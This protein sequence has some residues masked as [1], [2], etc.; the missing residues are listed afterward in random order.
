MRLRK[1]FFSLMGVLFV[2]VLLFLWLACDPLFRGALERYGP[3]ALGQPLSFDEAML[4]PLAGRA[5]ILGLKIG[6][7]ERPMIESGRLVAEVSPFRLLGGEFGIEL[8]AL[9][10]AT[11]RFR[12]D[13]QGRL[14]FDPGPPP[15][16]VSPE[17][18]SREQP[19]PTNPEDR[20][21]VEIVQEY[22]ERV[23][24]YKKYY[25]KTGLFG[26]GE[27][28][29]SA[30]EVPPPSRYRG[31]QGRASCLESD[32]GP[33]EGK[34]GRRFGIGHAGV[35]DL[36][37][38]TRDERTGKPILPV[39]DKLS[40]SMDRLGGVP[41]GEETPGRIAADG[42]LAGGGSF[43][44]ILELAR[45]AGP[46][47]LVLHVQGLSPSAFADLVRNSLPWRIEGRAIDLDADE[48]AFTQTSLKGELSLTLHGIRLQ[49]R[50][51]APDVLGL[52]AQEFSHLLN[53]ALEQG[54]VKLK[55]SLSGSPTRP[56]F[57]I[58]NE[59]ELDQL[60]GGALKKKG[61]DFLK[62]KAAGLSPFGSPPGNGKKKK[63]RRKGKG[64][65]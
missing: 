5:E 35:Q 55:L 59:T 65:G 4:S 25:E 39:F 1:G 40:F 61:A 29:P 52:P 20:D 15:E 11:L 50:R 64:G 24:E 28:S 30:K 42:V 8:A 51:S 56:T 62:E 63:G 38:E 33:P 54:P 43:G 46:S 41:G 16:G 19:A 31:R 58:R 34:P 10:R 3:Q 44:F 7:P 32:A 6:S 60:L 27:A 57:R 49:A 22:W 23:Q 36:H 2:L 21:F 17:R 37:L 53:Q 12:I 26:G 47:R 48:L 14:G 45:G 9:E 13:K 18:R